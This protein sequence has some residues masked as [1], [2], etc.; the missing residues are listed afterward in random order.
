MAKGKLN[1]PMTGGYTGGTPKVADNT[2]VK[3][4]KPSPGLSRNLAG[5]TRIVSPKK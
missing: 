2:T 4:I 5:G 1:S 3:S